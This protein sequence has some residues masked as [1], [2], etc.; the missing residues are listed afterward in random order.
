[1]LSIGIRFGY[2]VS[3]NDVDQAKYAGGAKVLMD[4]LIAVLNAG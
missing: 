4:S 1:M 2:P 3:G